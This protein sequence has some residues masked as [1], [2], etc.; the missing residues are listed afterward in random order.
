MKTKKLWGT[1]TLI[2][3]ILGTL[4]SFYS[5]GKDEE[6]CKCNGDCQGTQC[7]APCGSDCKC[8][9]P[10]NKLLGTWYLFDGEIQKQYLLTF[11]ADG[12]GYIRINNDDG[13]HFLYT[14]K[15]DKITTVMV[16]AEY[17]DAEDTV[18]FY[19]SGEYLVIAPEDEKKLV[20]TKG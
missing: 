18:T 15:G 3:L 13:E 1:A 10:K 17:E 11:N 5:C 14:V 12:S 8:T 4:V 2:V 7:S 16:A 20:F 9:Q 6:T 19:F